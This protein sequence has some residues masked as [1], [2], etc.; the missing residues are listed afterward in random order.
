MELPKKIKYFLLT[1][2]TGRK[3]SVGNFG[4]SKAT[5]PCV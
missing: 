5:S 3:Y 4:Y 1:T 2:P